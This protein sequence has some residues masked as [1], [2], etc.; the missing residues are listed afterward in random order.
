MDQGHR[1]DKIKFPV[2]LAADAVENP[3]AV[4]KFRAPAPAE[5]DAEV[6]KEQYF[7]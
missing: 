4:C 7:L 5:P 3:K 1:I 6:Q 2:K